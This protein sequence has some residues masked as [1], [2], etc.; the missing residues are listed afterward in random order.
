MAEKD[1]NNFSNSF[2]S[3]DNS[4]SSKPSR[5]ENEDLCSALNEQCK[6]GENEPSDLDSYLSSYGK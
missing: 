2:K 5:E 6:V 4:D 3:Q 1:A